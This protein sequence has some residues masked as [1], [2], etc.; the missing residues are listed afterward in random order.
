MA[1]TTI[2]PQWKSSYDP[3]TKKEPTMKPLFQFTT[4]K[5]NAEVIW[6]TLST[7]DDIVATTGYTV[8]EIKFYMFVVLQLRTDFKSAKELCNNYESRTA[9]LKTAMV[10]LLSLPTDQS[11][12]HLRV[13]PAD[14][15]VWVDPTMYIPYYMLKQLG[16]INIEVLARLF[17][18]GSMSNEEMSHITADKDTLDNSITAYKL[19]YYGNNISTEK[20][21]DIFSIIEVLD[22]RL[23]FTQADIL[24]DLNRSMYDYLVDS[25]SHI[26]DYSHKILIPP[27]TLG[28]TDA[29]Q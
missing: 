5:P 9:E 20:Y 2:H 10:A 4:V 11:F 3:Y 27:F 28:V 19:W 26:Y 16:D 29:S 23:V 18:R 24:I 22:P 1:V 14:L 7:H 25:S 8:D 13:P 12:I 6:N 15:P 21:S 17:N